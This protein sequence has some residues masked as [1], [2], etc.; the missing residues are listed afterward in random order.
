MPAGSYQE[1]NPYLLLQTSVSAFLSYLSVSL[2]PKSF[3]E[4]QFSDDGFADLI[5]SQAATCPTSGIV[6]SA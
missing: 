2:G 6:P 4:Q 3:S 1:T 5:D